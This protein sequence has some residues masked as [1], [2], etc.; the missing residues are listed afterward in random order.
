M[1]PLSLLLMALLAA[2]ALAQRPEPPRPAER[3]V[4]LTH[5]GVTRIDPFY[6]MRDRDD[7]EVLAHLHA[8]NA[9]T[10]AVLAPVADLREE[11]FREIVGRIQQDDAS[12]P[13][14]ENGFYYY[15]RFEEGQEY[16]IYARRRGSLDAPEEVLLDVNRLAEGHAYYHV[17]SIAVSDD[18]R[19]LAFAAD[20][21]GRRLYRLFVKDLTTGETLP[22]SLYPTTG[23]VVWAA[24]GAT[25]FVGRQDPQTLRAYQILRWRVG[26]DPARAEVV[27]Q[28]D[29]ETFYTAVTRTK[30]GAFLA[31]GS[32]QT[33]STEWRLL[34]ADR[35]EGTFRVVAPRRRDHRYSIDH[36]DGYV[37]VLSNADG[38]LNNRLLRA[39]EATPGEEHWEE[40]VPH[41]E[42]VLLEDFEL[43]RHALVLQERER[44]L[45]R[46]RVLPWDGSPPYDVAFDDPTYTAAFGVNRTFDTDRLQFVY[47]SMT[48]PQTTYELDLRTR[49]RTLLKRDPVLGDFDPAHYVSERL[50]ARAED[51]T[52]IPISLVY[53]RGTPRDGTAPLLLYGY[54]A[55]GY[56]LE[57]GFSVA[58]LSLLDRGFVYAI[59]H[60]RG[61]QEL[62]R[63][64]YEEGKLLRKKNTF[65]D[66]IAAAE[67]L[68]AEGYA[69][70]DRLYAMG[71]S[72][73]GLLVGAVLNLRPDL[74]DGAVAAVPFV[75]VVTTMLDETIPLTTFEYDE[76]GNP[77]EEEAFHYMLAYSPYDNVRPVP[78]P[79][80]LVTSGLHDSQVQFWEPTKWVARL[81]ATTTGD[82]PILLRTNMEAGHGG[83]SGRFQ[84]FREIAEEFAFLIGLAE[85]RL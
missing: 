72:A 12:A 56:S 43:F 82:R 83:A 48:T 54:G 73:G 84:R 4:A 45:P 39:P 2:P 40:L 46:L 36:A 34:E 42:D 49:E 58:R 85:R 23:N 1:R 21:V 76:W 6:W 10:D 81:R 9:Y 27:F 64:W 35:P 80:L 53:R 62:G 70:P 69:D 7:P 5:H 28:E 25:L 50:Y 31:I 24:D 33:L 32:F 17:R 8:E 30:S 60:V 44:G 29:D 37:Y 75:D 18:G 11:L 19:R 68:V 65:T 47:A 66:F 13:Y 16:P 71:G 67:H 3:P 74:F 78:Y 79:A 38:A 52:E 59:A 57:A 14:F 15:T 55:Y 63:R 51:G 26:D 61:G 22:Q 77:N 20:T 41:R